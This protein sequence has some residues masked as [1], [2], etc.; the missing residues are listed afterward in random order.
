MK[1]AS[2]N[3]DTSRGTQIA[4]LE[5]AWAQ[6]LSQLTALQAR[7]GALEAAQ[8]AQQETL[9]RLTGPVAEPGLAARAHSAV[10]DADA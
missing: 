1:K 10:E 6:L 4:K 2:A 7:V 3:R 8:K 5:R 9:A